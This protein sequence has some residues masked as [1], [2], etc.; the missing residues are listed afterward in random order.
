MTQLAQWQISSSDGSADLS[1]Q[2][3]NMTTTIHSNNASIQSLQAQIQSIQNSI[4]QFAALQYV[5]MDYNTSSIPVGQTGIFDIPFPQGV[6]GILIKTIFVQAQTDG[7][8]FDTQILTA[9]TGG[10]VIYKSTQVSNV[11]YDMVDLPYKDGSGNNQLHLMIE[12]T[13]TSTVASTFTVIITGI[14][15]I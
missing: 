15:I 13:G 5:E 7:A 9:D 14:A 11:L 4:S 1:I 3:T 10:R 6:Q 8:I 12:N 2:L